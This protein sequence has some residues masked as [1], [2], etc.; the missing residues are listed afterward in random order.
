MMKR[1]G[2]IRHLEREGCVFVREGG[3]HTLYQNPANGAFTT[4]PRHRAVK[5]NVARKICD[6]LGVPRPQ[7]L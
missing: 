6:D 5:K 1:A 2:L 7:N 3:R 4:I